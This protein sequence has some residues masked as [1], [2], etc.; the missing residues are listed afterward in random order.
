V[1]LPGEELFVL[2]RCNCDNEALSEAEM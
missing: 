1:T 2:G